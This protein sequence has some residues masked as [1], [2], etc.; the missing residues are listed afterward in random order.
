VDFFAC[1]LAAVHLVG[2]RMQWSRDVRGAL[3][4]LVPL[5]NTSYLGYPMTQAF[6]GAQG[7]PYAIVFDQIGN[8]LLLA[9][10]VPFVQA[11]FGGQPT[12]ASW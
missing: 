2:Q 11:R 6:Y 10:L 4:L 5:G 3:L 1:T 7:M 8:F 9:M 12:Q